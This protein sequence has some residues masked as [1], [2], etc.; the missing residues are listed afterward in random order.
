MSLL[1][2]TKQTITIQ[3]FSLNYS[4]GRKKCVFVIIQCVWR[5]S[6]LL[7]TDTTNHDSFLNVES[8]TPGNAHILKS[9]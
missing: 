6:I 1:R 3:V 9:S 2:Q 5:W 8:K 4:W 7:Y